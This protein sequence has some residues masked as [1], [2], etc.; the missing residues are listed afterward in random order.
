MTQNRSGDV[1]AT[2]TS[3]GGD[4]RCWWVLGFD[5]VLGLRRMRGA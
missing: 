5:V 3:G 1:A 4:Q 2:G